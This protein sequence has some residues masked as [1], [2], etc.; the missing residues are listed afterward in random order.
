VVGRLAEKHPHLVR[1][2]AAEG[3]EVGNHSYLH[4][5]LH[6]L[7]ARE[8]VRGVLR[9]QRLLGELT[10]RTPTLYRPP[11]GKVSIRKV[12][13]AWRLGLAVA[14]WNVDPRDY[15]CEST[16]DLLAW[17]GGRPLRGGDIVLFHDR[18]PRAEAVLPELVRASCDRGLTFGPLTAFTLPGGARQEKTA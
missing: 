16:A 10:G 9:T 11:R 4:A 12:W 2:I 18:L 6:H 15:A 7:T 8:A 1:R 14:L 3:H 5:H 17:F 13:G